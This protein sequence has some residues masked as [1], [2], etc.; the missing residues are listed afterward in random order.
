MIE[1]L[2]T[3]A[4]IIFILLALSF[5]FLVVAVVSAMQPSNPIVALISGIMF[6][7]AFGA[8]I[9]L[10]IFS[11]TIPESTSAWTQIYTNDVNASVVIDYGENHKVTAGNVLDRYGEA[12]LSRRPGGFAT[13]IIKNGEDES[14]RKVI[15]RH[16]E[17]DVNGNSAITKIEYRPTPTMHYQLFGVDGYSQTSHF[18][19]EVRIT[20]SKQTNS[21]DT[22]FGD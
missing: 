11:K 17:G 4:R 2:I 15:V 10:G 13:V 20:V 19:G 5:I 16:I 1:W 9:T 14:R 8:L 22:I 18:D 7:F 12:D 3:D 6:V 21:A